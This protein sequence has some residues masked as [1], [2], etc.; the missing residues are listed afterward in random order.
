MSCAF[1][2]LFAA[3]YKA[4]CCLS[5]ITLNCERS[6]ILLLHYMKTGHGEKLIPLTYFLETICVHLPLYVQGIFNFSVFNFVFC[7]HVRGHVS[8]AENLNKY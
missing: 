3:N 6:S 2:G 4:V 1:L 8:D 7:M 5:L